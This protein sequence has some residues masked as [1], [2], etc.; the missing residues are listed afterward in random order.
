MKSPVRYRRQIPFFYDKSE[1]EIQEDP[2]ERYDPTVIRQSTLHLCDHL[3]NG[4]P[5]QAILDF[6]KGHLPESPVNIAE[7]GC[8]VGRWIAELAQQYP[9]AN[10]WGLDYS[11]QMCRQANDYWT[12]GTSLQLN[13]S[14]RGFSDLISQEGHHIPNLNFGLAKADQLPFEDQSQDLLLHSFLLDRLPKPMAGLKEF[15]RVL[16]PNGLM[17]FAT[18]LNFHQPEHWSNFYPPVKLYH[19]LSSIF[20][21]IDWKEGIKILEPLDSHGNG[22]QWNCLGVVARKK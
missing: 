11:Y 21:I 22:I 5:M 18:P 20:E 7:I 3:W 4:Y 16:K 15:L 2:Y 17:C 12:K 13:L 19:S 8:S 1:S 14:N 9:N 10:C 6:A